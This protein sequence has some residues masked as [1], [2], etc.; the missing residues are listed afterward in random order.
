MLNKPCKLTGELK[1]KCDY[2]RPWL[3]D[4]EIDF[5]IT[6]ASLFDTHAT[7]TVFVILGVVNGLADVATNTKRL[8]ENQVEI[9]DSMKPYIGEEGGRLLTKALTEHIQ[10]AASV[11]TTA[12]AAAEGR[13]DAAALIEAKKKALFLNSDK[14]ASLI[15]GV[16]TLPLEDS[17]QMWRIHNE[18]VI[19]MTE[20]QLTKNYEAFVSRYD[21]Y[22]REIFAM[23]NAIYEALPPIL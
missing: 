16:T 4:V 19:K 1:C 6:L 22:K 5:R 18:L 20:A 17:K 10:L 7:Y 8:L 12:T 21:A 13:A 9:G 3:G 14:V 11:I 2:E 23:V 15:S